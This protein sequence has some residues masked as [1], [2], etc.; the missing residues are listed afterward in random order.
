MKRVRRVLLTGWFS[1]THGEATAGDLL[2]L[3][4]VRVLLEQAGEA[5]DVA[6][7]PGFRPSGPSLA[8]ARPDAYSHLVFVCGPLAG[9]Q[10]EELHQRYAHCVRIA[11]GTSTL[12]GGSPA[13]R[14]F[15][16]VLPRDATGLSPTP[17]L[18]AR[19][20]FRPGPPLVG[21]ILTHGQHEYGDRRLHEHVAREVT[22][23]LATRDCARLQLDTRLDA[24]D[25]RLCATPEQLASA[26][27]RCDLIITDRLHGLVLALRE[28]VPALAVDPIADGAKVTAQA[29]ACHWPALLPAE[30]LSPH[31]LDHWWTWCTTVGR[32][33]AHEIASG[34]RRG[35]GVDSADEL[36]GMLAEPLPGTSGPANSRHGEPR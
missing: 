25:W 24:H 10:I 3:D 2:A 15:H 9:A 26:L 21:V 34:F 32:E 4:R 8:D 18:A 13:V 5:Y 31:A 30:R 14:G 16:H 36:L 1:F 22:D 19:A 23:W 35:E 27:S 6:W 7:S 28:G 20:P 29:H 11:V 12:D 33:H 17:D